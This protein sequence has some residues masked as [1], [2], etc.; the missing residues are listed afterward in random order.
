MYRDP[1]GATKPVESLNVACREKP[2]H[3]ILGGIA[4]FMYVFFDDA[5]DTETF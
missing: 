3:I 2:V 5:V 1:E 4:D